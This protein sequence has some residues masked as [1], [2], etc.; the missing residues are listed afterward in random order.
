MKK[1]L[2]LFLIVLA[3]APG[4][5]QREHFVFINHQEKLPF[6]VRMGEQIFSSSL[7]GHLTIAPLSDSVYAMYV[8]FPRS[9]FPEQLFEVRVASADKGLLL[10]NQGGSWQ[11]TDQL[12]GEV[13]KPVNTSGLS[14]DMQLKRKQD[15]YSMLM[16]DVVDDSSVLYT[17][18]QSEERTAESASPVVAADSPAVVA[19]A[20]KEG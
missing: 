8:G 14:G 4:F 15:S 20:S 19:R 10:S 3:G 7:V 6:Y 9:R 11:L 5:A 2:T 17:V 18:N 16:A 1:M 12:T 13:I